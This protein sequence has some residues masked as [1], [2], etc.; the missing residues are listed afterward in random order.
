MRTLPQESHPFWV[1]VMIPLVRWLVLAGAAGALAI[2]LAGEIRDPVLLNNPEDLEAVATEEGAYTLTAL[3]DRL[4]PEGV[5]IVNRNI[6]YFQ[7]TGRGRLSRGLARSGKYLDTF[8]KVFRDMGMPEELAY[9]PLIESGFMPQVV[10]SAQA[11][12]LW[13]FIAETGRRYNL[14][15]NDWA[16]KRLDPFQSGVAA[17]HLLRNLYKKF[18]N[19]EL[20]LAAYN[21]G[22]GT[23][24]WAIRKNKKAGLPTHFWAL[25]LPAETTNYV[26]HFLAAVL[27]AKHP[28]AHGFKKIAFQPKLTYDFLKVTPGTSLFY[29]ADEGG[30]PQKTLLELNPALIRGTV[31][32]GSKPY[33][34]RVPPGSRRQLTAKLTGVKS[35]LRDWLVHQVEYTDTVELL[36]SRFRSNSANI[37]KANG[38]ENDQ[39]LT[40]R[41]FVIIPL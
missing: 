38:L 20:A 26:P 25:D 36:A 30:I 13:Q 21:S 14:P 33:T 34:L 15:S 11:V 27:I 9:L 12:G 41:N 37:L 5:N 19:W 2:V 23:V 29:L 17:A 7:T 8:K 22:A 16:D 31:P 32:P 4:T 10:S 28:R 35:S 24:R 3:Y 1:V 18:G 39:E 6:R 40:L